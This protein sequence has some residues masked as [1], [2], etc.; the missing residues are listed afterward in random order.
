MI[1]D[2]KLTFRDHINYITEKCTK[3]I[4]VVAKSAKINWGLVHKALK[5]I[6]VRRNIAPST[7]RRSSMDKG[8]GKRKIQK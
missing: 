5:T 1:F 2:Y 3:L 8:N 6:Y 4:F 7:I